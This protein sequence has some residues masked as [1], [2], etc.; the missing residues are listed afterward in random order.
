MTESTIPENSAAAPAA[1]VADQMTKKVVNFRS[2]LHTLK[3]PINKSWRP[4]RD[5]L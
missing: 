2:P 1:T 5:Y 4:E 3:S